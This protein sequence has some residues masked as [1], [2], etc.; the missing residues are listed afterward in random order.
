MEFQQH[1][2]L[3]FNV[4]G[5]AGQ[6]CEAVNVSSMNVIHSNTVKGTRITKKDSKPLA[7]DSTE[8]RYPGD[9]TGW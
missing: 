7:Q 3:F 8:G 6:K 9:Q 4:R 1:L 2:P 5:D